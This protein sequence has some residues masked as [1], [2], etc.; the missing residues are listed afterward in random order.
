MRE[1]TV[2]LVVAHRG[3]SAEFPENTLAAFRAAASRGADGVELDVRRTAD[4][5]L[6]VHH[7]AHLA[8]GRAIV[9]LPRTALPDSIPTLEAALAACSGVGVNIEIKNIPGDP[10][11]DADCDVAARTVA[12]IRNTMP[13]DEAIVSSFNYDDIMKVR[14]LDPDI[15]TG[16]LVLD[17]AD[18]DALL[19]HVVR[20]GHRALH[21]PV[22]H[23]TPDV[24]AAAHVREVLVNTWTVDDPERIVHLAKMGVDAVIT[25]D[26]HRARAALD[27]WRR[28][29]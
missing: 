29:A 21:P 4:G 17:V 22:E 3:V 28:G 6:V 20:D 27:A 11:Y 16:W 23:T 2:P 14:R 24:V 1:R 5:A 7:D 12:V 10:D 26:P 9:E 13:I 8:D 19:V 18:V 15:A 25:N